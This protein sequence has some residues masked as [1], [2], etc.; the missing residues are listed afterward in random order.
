MTQEICKCRAYP[1]PHRL[2]GGVCCN[3]SLD[4]PICE[5]CLCHCNGVWVDFGIGS[6]EF[7]GARGFDTRWEYV[8][9]CCEADLFTDQSCERFYDP[10]ELFEEPDRWEEMEH[11]YES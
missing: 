11:H 1:F 6:Y 5:E 7:W 3:T 10:P 4:E 8:S 2:G 9:D